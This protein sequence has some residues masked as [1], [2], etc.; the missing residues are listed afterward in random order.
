[1]EQNLFEAKGKEYDNHFPLQHKS[2]NFYAN[3]AFKEWYNIKK[4]YVKKENEK[5]ALLTEEN[6]KKYGFDERYM[7]FSYCPNCISYAICFVKDD[8][9]F[10]K[11]K[12]CKKEFCIGCYRNKIYNEEETMCLKGF[13]ILFYHRFIDQR[14]EN[15]NYR[16]FLYCLHI[17]VCL[18]L[19]PIYLGM[20]SYYIGFAVHRK[21]R[22]S[23]FENALYYGKS[24]FF[25]F[26]FSL[27][28]GLLMFPYI[29]TFFPFMLILLLPGIFSYNY[30]VYIYNM[31]I[32]I[33]KPGNIRDLNVK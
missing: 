6:V 28:R 3:P 24:C 25:S 13:L 32:I 7:V 29:I 23:F 15:T 33:F 1:M 5:R 21:K 16:P 19:T 4:E 31:Y 20:I 27:L 22:G 10:V 17:F 2:E 9:S 8:Y 11:C 14:S 18:F 12:N 26:F 30:Y